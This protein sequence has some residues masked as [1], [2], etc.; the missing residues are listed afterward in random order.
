[1][2]KILRAHAYEHVELICA[3]LCRLPAHW[4]EAIQDLPWIILPDSLS[5]LWIGLL[6]REQKTL[7]GRLYSQ[8]G[9]WYCPEREGASN[10][11]LAPHVYLTPGGVYGAVHEV[12]HALED[13][14][15]VPVADFYR[16]EVAFYPYMALNAVEYFACALDAFLAPERGED[17]FGFNCADLARLNPAL[18]VYLGRKLEALN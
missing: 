7:D 15:R 3:S 17:A 12:G 9:G 5:P 1:M 13:A 6:E 4:L 18:Y 2:L 16:P 8:V 11:H 14:W 10:W